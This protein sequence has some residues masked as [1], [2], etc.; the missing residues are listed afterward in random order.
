MTGGGAV[1]LHFNGALH[2]EISND[3]ANADAWKQGGDFTQGVAR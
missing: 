2:K 3:A 1:A